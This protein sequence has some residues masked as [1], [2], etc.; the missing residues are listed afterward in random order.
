MLIADFHLFTGWKYSTGF[1][2][3]EMIQLHLFPPGP[4][5]L[6]LMCGPPPMVNFACIPNLEKL[7]YDSKL[8]FAY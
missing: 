4:D 8:R 5:T 6:V 1:I 2:N 3:A 7:G